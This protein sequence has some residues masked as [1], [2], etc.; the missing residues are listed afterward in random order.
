V[1]MYA[2]VR[3]CVLINGWSNLVAMQEGEQQTH[4]AGGTMR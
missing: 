2:H 1:C 4:I 3:A